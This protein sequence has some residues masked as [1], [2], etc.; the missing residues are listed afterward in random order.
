M[1]Q[2]GRSR[3]QVV[4]VRK[5]RSTSLPSRPASFEN[6]PLQPNWNKLEQVLDYSHSLDKVSQVI[7]VDMEQ[8]KDIKKSLVEYELL[9]ERV[10]NKAQQKRTAQKA[11][12]LLGHDP[13]TEKLK[14]T[15]GLDDVD[16]ERMRM[17]NSENEE[18]RLLK[19]RIMDTP[20][21]KKQ[22]A[23]ALSTLG[24]D[25]SVHRSMKILGIKE[26]SLRKAISEENLKVEK[27]IMH[28]RKHL[29][30][31]NRKDNKK[32]LHV[33]GHDPSK[34]KIIHQ[35]GAEATKDIN[36]GSFRIKGQG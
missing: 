9:K 23:K 16:I 22:S 5:R 18:N 2:R 26:A 7:G 8:I 24:F 28:S 25:P 11:L 12:D 21:D 33:I 15:L 20:Y 4:P 31:R 14:K 35:L 29:V 6:V 36:W 10:L 30:S 27:R 19:K 32:A 34:E 1:E 3:T 17:E 13:S